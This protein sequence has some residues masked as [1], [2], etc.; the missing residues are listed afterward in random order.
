MLMSLCNGKAM[1]RGSSENRAQLS[2]QQTN[3]ASPRLFLPHATV[4][5]KLT[6]APFPHSQ[7]PENEVKASQSLFRVGQSKATTR[8]H[9]T[10]K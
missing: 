8:G 1:R 4:V 5:K 3:F 2:L 10:K 9:A 7:I 6:D